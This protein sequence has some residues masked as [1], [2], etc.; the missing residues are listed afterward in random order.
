MLGTNT[1]IHSTATTVTGSSQP[2]GT[3]N[4][5]ALHCGVHGLPVGD[6]F[7]AEFVE[8]KPDTAVTLLGCFEL[9]SAP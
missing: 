9:S 8:N 7:I 4:P 5:E 2:T 3:P 1:D 6:Y